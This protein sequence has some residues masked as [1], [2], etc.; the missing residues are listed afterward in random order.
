[1][2]WLQ[3]IID[4]FARISQEIEIVLD[5]LTV[6]EINQQPRPDCNSIAWLTWHLTRSHD[7]NMSEIAGKEQLWISD[8]WHARFNL[9]PNPTE[10]GYKHTTEE[11]TAFKAP[12]TETI[13]EYH[14]AVLERIKD[15]VKNTLSEDELKREH[16]S[17]TFGN[18]VTVRRRITGVMCDA[19][20]HVGQAAYV[21]G[22]LK[23]RGWLNR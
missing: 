8:N 18:T 20:E 14:Y 16:I 21:R 3:L 2:E 22:L 15:Y 10:T 23:G 19:L 9:P 11:A 6:E 1:M 5:G 12:D 7:R 13:L 4:I 17:P